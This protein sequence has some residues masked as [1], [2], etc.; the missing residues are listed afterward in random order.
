MDRLAET[1]KLLSGRQHLLLI[2]LE[3]LKDG[4]HRLREPGED[5]LP[6]RRSRPGALPDCGR[7][8][9]KWTCL[10]PPLT[11]PSARIRL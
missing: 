7:H 2:Y 10:Y 3:F 9:P 4:C 1:G 8:A 11:E 5:P 6:G